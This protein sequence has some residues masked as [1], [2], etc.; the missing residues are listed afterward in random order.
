MTDAFIADHTSPI[1]LN[2]L[3]VTHSTIGGDALVVG[4]SGELDLAGSSVAVAAC[5]DG[6]HL[7]VTV[8]LRELVFMDCAGYSG[9]EAAR[10]IVTGRGGSFSLT[11][12]SGEPARLLALVEDLPSRPMNK[13][14]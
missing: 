12:A 4:L 7:S 5:V 10:T 11:N 13:A 8:D 9:L 3:L 1:E 2:R 6:P 14:A